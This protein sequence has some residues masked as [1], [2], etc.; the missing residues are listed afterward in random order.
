MY[1]DQNAARQETGRIKKSSNR[2]HQYD[3]ARNYTSSPRDRGRGGGGSKEGIHSGGKGKQSLLSSRSTTCSTTRPETHEERGGGAS[4]RNAG[5][6]EPARPMRSEV[7]LSL[8]QSRRGTRKEEAE[9]RSSNLLYSGPVGRTY[10]ICA[11][12]I[13]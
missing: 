5:K 6:M 1:L 12:Q 8:A 10:K 3:S 11:I 13:L 9:K 4:K 7:I 2:D